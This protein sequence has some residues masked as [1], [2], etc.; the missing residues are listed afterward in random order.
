MFYSY[1]LTAA[2][3]E[4]QVP[5]GTYPKSINSDRLVVKYRTDNKDVPIIC[6]LSLLSSVYL[7]DF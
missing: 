4:L 2:R 5:Q 7:L 1:R 6:S 3:L